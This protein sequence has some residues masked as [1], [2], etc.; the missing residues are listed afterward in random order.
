MGIPRSDSWCRQS[1][2]LGLQ[3]RWLVQMYGLALNCSSLSVYEIGVDPEARFPYS[4]THL[5]AVTSFAAAAV[6]P[7]W[8]EDG[9]TE[10]ATASSTALSR[11][12]FSPALLRLLK[13]F[14]ACPRLD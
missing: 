14:P 9:E 13:K 7:H 5:F 10:K 3:N 1:S 12:L 4:R 8:R 11:F 2:A 6:I